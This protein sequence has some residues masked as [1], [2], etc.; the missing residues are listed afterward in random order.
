MCGISKDNSPLA[1]VVYVYPLTGI[2]NHWFDTFQTAY[3]L[4]MK[5]RQERKGRLQTEE[6]RKVA[7][8]SLKNWKGKLDSHGFRILKDQVR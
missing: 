8:E 2:F 5:I 4:A 1:V 7:H 6:D 3:D